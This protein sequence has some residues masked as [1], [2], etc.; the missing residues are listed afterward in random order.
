[1]EATATLDVVKTKSPQETR[2]IAANFA[3]T[4]KAGD[5]VATYGDLGAGKTV[6]VQG[7][8]KGLGI[9]SRVLS[10]TFVF[11]RLYPIRFE[12]RKLT[13]YHIDLF[14]GENKEDYDALGLGEIFSQKSI[15]VIEWAE[16][17]KDI[18]PKKRIDV[19]LEVVDEKTRRI[20]IQRN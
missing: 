11:I 4:L 12:G 19:F 15:T 13:F 7:I 18:L 9:E 6:F 8:A 17:I 2:Q 3:K 5:V 16:K 1:M 20:A 14:R 10:P